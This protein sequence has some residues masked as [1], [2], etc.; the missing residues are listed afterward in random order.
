MKNRLPIAVGPG[1]QPAPPHLQLR[2]AARAYGTRR[3]FSGLSVQLGA[4]V[5]GILGPNGA[6][7]TTLLECL[8]TLVPPDEGS[9]EV[10]GSIVDGEGAAR[11]VR[12]SIGFMP[13]DFGFIRSMTVRETVDYALWA[14]ETD[15]PDGSAVSDALD[16]L[17]LT[18]DAS[19]KMKTLSGGTVQRVGLACALVA[20]PKILVLDEPTVGLDPA[21]RIGLRSALAA[22]SGACVALSTHNVDDVM[23]VADRVIVLLA[24]RIVFDGTPHDL[25]QQDHGGPGNTAAERG[26][27]NLVGE[28]R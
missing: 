26:Y 9:L 22:D 6:G 15:D 4:G 25:S 1:Q 8:A 17:R 13:Q 21:Q 27:M 18:S 23:A 14:R 28:T 24:G 19:R 11:R 7:K 12:R 20:H 3:V 10:L 5:T 2:S 16:L